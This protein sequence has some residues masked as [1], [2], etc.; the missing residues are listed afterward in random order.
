MTSCA[1][2]CSNWLTDLM[3]MIDYVRAIF[4][5]LLDAIDAKYSTPTAL[6]Q[7][8]ATVSPAVHVI[9]VDFLASKATLTEDPKLPSCLE[10]NRMLS[11]L[12]LL[13]PALNSY[14]EPGII[15]LENFIVCP[16]KERPPW[17]AG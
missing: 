13:L 15:I 14:D 8:L 11:T 10:S 2:T 16:R 6:T 12:Q 7:L 4:I 1:E 17:L 5:A 9:L 3:A